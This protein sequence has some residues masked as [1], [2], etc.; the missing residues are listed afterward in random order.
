MLAEVQMA[1]RRR[2]VARL[3]KTHIPALLIGAAVFC[4]PAPSRAIE[5]SSTAGRSAG[6][7]SARRSFR[8][9]VSITVQSRSTTPDH[10]FNGSGE[11]VAALNALEI[12][13]FRAGPFLWYVPDIK[14]LDGSIGFCA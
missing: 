1:K 14:L 4:T 8:P 11:P 5:G 10:F 13:R 9:L 7:T 2:A 3:T 6:P 12:E